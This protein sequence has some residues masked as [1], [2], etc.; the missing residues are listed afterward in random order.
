MKKKLIDQMVDRFLCWKLPADFAPDCGISF[1][2]RQDDELNK[3]KSWPTGTNLF[4]AGQ[5]KEMFSHCLGNESAQLPEVGSAFGGGF[6]G[7]EMIIAGHRY[8][9]IVAPKAEGENMELGYKSN[10]RSTADGTDS[11]DDGMINAN[12]INDE[13]HPAAHFCR[14]LAI[15]GHND[16]YLPSRD[17]LMMLWRNLGPRRK[18]VPELFRGDAAEAFE[19]KWYWSSTEYA[20]YSDPAWIVG[21]LSG[22]QSY[23]VKDYGCGVRAVRRI[24]L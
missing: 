6:F 7:G 5:V 18:N 1:D 15:G 22:S 2:G 4:T 16:W 11:D 14:S 20:Q 21:F 3:N 19:E 13:N 8:A 9:L 12:L 10:D 23:Y 24:Q 17:E